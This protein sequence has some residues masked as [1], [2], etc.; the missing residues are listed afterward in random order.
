M[1]AIEIKIRPLIENDLLDADRIF[2]LAFGTFIGLP[3]PMTFAGDADFVRT[4]WLADP[5]SALGAESA[6]ELIGSNFLTNWGSVGFFGPLT[7]RPD[8]W[9]KGVARRL[10]EPTMD[11]FAEWGTKLAGLFTFAQSTKH[12]HLYQKFGFW[13]QFLTALMT[14]PIDRNVTASSWSLFSEMAAQERAGC[15]EACAELTGAIYEGLDVGREIR[16]IV[17]QNLGDTVLFW[18]GPGLA[19]FAA[20]HCGAGTEAGSGALYIKFGAARPG[21]AAEGN[22]NR[23]LEACEAFAASR[24]LEKL[25]AGVNTSRAAAYRQML[26]RGFRSFIQGIAMQRSEGRGYN[27]QDV[28]VID[29]WR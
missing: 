11:I 3:D 24:G 6:G 27:R 13:P 18:D 7:V 16:T 22:F 21:P 4:R 23:I 12:V 1:T 9:N 19:G 2:R 5:Y 10:L 28:Y 8:F 15:L 14:K 25:V 20:C 26:A 29:D 17:E